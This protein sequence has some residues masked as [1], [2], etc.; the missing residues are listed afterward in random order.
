MGLR[1]LGCAKDLRNK[2]MVTRLGDVDVWYCD[3]CNTYYDKQEI[4]DLIFSR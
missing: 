3:G 4:K 2:I 1:C